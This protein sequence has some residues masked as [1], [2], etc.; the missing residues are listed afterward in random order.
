MTDSVEE[1]K[2]VIAP[3]ARRP[4]SYCWLPVASLEPGMVLA[5]PLVHGSG[6]SAT[7]FLAAGSRVTASAIA[8]IINRGVECIAVNSKTRPNEEASASCA[9]EYEKRLR[10]IFGEHPDAD[11]Q[12][13][14]D[15]LLAEGPD[16]A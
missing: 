1:I 2:P 6:D 16:A 4:R 9:L 3:P 11:C 7:I 14:L 15:A 13:L 5:K 8:Q 12:A 10:D